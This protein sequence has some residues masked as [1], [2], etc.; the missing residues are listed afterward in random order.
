MDG[1]NYFVLLIL[2]ITSD[3]TKKI[4]NIIFWDLG[5]RIYN[6]KDTKYLSNMWPNQI[7]TYLAVGG[8]FFQVNEFVDFINLESSLVYIKVGKHLVI[9]LKI[10]NCGFSQ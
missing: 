8:K 5:A 9:E 4:Q 6:Q 10:K 2:R 7:Y 1:I 3:L